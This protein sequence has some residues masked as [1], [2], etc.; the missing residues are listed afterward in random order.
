MLTN[1]HIH[2]PRRY[3][4]HLPTLI[5]N[6]NTC[7]M[8]A[9]SQSQLHVPRSLLR[10]MIPSVTAQKAPTK[11][12]LNPLVAQFTIMALLTPLK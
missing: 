9:S 5:S 2:L 1:F 4:F 7:G 8:L 11:L 10:Y 12:Y 6:V 3:I